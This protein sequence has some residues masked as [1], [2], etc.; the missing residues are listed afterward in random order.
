MATAK[1]LIDG[2]KHATSELAEHLERYRQ[3]ESA[4]REA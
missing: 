1:G 2:I 4:Q 3:S